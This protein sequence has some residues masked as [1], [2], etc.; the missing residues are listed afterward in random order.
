[1]A[2]KAGTAGANLSEWDYFPPSFRPPV[3]TALDLSYRYDAPQ[4]LERAVTR[5]HETY[6]SHARQADGSLPPFPMLAA[7]GGDPALYLGF[8][9]PF[10]NR[11]VRLYLAVAEQE[12]R[13]APLSVVWEYRAADG[14]KPLGVQDETAHLTQPGMVEFLGPSDLALASGPGASR[15]WI[16]ARLASGDGSR[17]GLRGVFPHAVWAQ[18]AVTLLNEGLGSSTGRPD[19]V[20]RLSR[21]PVLAG[22]QIEVR[23]PEIPSA[24][25]LQAL[26][27]DGEA[28]PVRLTRDPGGRIT[29][30][31]VRW[32]GVEHFHLSGPGSRHYAVDRLAGQIRFGNGIRGMI[33]PAGR[34]NI[35]AARYRAGGGR[36][37]NV[38]AGALAVM[39]RAIASIDRVT[40]PVPAGGGSDQEGL[41]AVATR[42]PLLLKHRDRAVSAE[43]YEWL[44]REASLQVARVRC[45]PA[46]DAATAGE[47]RLIILPDSDE[48]MPRPAP[49]LLRLVQERLDARRIG[50]ADLMLLPPAYVEVSVTAEVVPVSLEEADA[51]GRRV[52][53]RLTAYLHPL[54]GG[55]GGSGWPFGRDV[56]AS[57]VAAVIERIQGV[58][59]LKGLTLHGWAEGEDRARED[60]RRVEVREEKGELVASGEHS[61]LMAA[62]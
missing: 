41:E 14:W 11:P 30:A 27:E 10:A 31:W 17:V 43:D 46:R 51:V 6:G 44:A 58:D 22:E 33:P 61:I 52:A 9:L 57:E 62:S 59:Y 3:I 15:Y 56:Y 37:G 49:G 26:A 42:G 36:S 39:K 23:E 5:D 16:R 13:P 47:V 18:H 1:M 29:E 38:A 45:L 19:L 28:D 8:D 12:A 21:S 32:H 20:C 34:D 7:L 2:K 54:R 50:T 4:A 40:N 25:A 35:R 48:R 60:G 55:P 53:D 24:E